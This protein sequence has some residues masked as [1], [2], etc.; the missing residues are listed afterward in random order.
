MSSPVAGG[1]TGPPRHAWELVTRV[2]AHLPTGTDLTDAEFERRHRAILYLIWAQAAGTL[3]FGLVQR[4]SRLEVVTEALLIGS[5]GAVAAI[6]VLAPRFRAAI[7]TLALISTSAAIDTSAFG[8]F[9][10]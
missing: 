3:V 1:V 8:R 5:L 4:A 7:S 6:K 9:R 2:V 10:N